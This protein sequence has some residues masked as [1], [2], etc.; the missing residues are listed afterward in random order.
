METKEN[1][2]LIV[3][4]IETALA[5]ENVTNQVIAKLKSDYSGLKINGIEDKEGFKKVEDGRKEAKKLRCLAVN[6]C[7]AGREKAN[8]ESKDWIAKQKEVVAQISE[9]EDELEKES[10]RIKELEKQILFE[11]IQKEKLPIRKEK[12]MTIG[13]E[14]ED[15]QLLKIDDNQFNTLFNEFHEK[16]L[17]EKAEKL[18][19]EQEQIEAERKEQLRIETERLAEIKRQEDLKQAAENARIEAERK[20][21]ETIELAEKAKQEAEQKA[22]E[23]AKK[24]EQDKKDALIKAEKDKQEAIDKLKRDQE[25][26][27]SAELKAKQEAEIAEQNRIA[28]EKKAALAAEKKAAKAPDKEKM[29]KWIEDLSLPFIELKQ[30]ESNIMASDIKVKFEAFKNWA[31]KQIET[32]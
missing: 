20:E 27:E 14:I 1:E 5:K 25:A 22:I 11:A 29:T 9:I 26:K 21:K 31:K 17:S 18:K 12:L 13:V 23:A 24:A 7:E 15:G 10:D 8:K 32:I 16:I 28:E 3:N 6:I 4:P 30:N 2:V 19:L